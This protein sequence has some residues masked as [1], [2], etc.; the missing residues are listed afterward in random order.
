MQEAEGEADPY[1]S[2]GRNGASGGAQ[3]ARGINC[4]HR[5]MAK[6]TQHS[7]IVDLSCPPRVSGNQGALL[8][9]IGR[10][11]VF[12]IQRSNLDA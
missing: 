12:R 3:R 9:R 6:T 1:L 4:R 7:G 8:E 5:P 11:D 2:K 10:F